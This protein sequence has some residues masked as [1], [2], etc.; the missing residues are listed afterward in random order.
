[1]R[2][3]LTELVSQ[4]PVHV[5]AQYRPGTNLRASFYWGFGCLRLRLRSLRRSDR[6][7]N[8]GSREIRVGSVVVMAGRSNLGCSCRDGFNKARYL[9]VN[10]TTK[11]ERSSRC[12]VPGH[13][14]VRRALRA[15]QHLLKVQPVH[16]HPHST[17][18]GRIHEQQSW[19]PRALGFLP[20]HRRVARKT[21][22]WRA[23]EEWVTGY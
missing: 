19:A 8:N 1:M 11:I 21:R 7:G 2:H 23:H 17:A 14:S 15:A 13:R 18:R 9:V 5:R 4:S 3:S 6:V 16:P 12:G 10:E 20:P 22:Q